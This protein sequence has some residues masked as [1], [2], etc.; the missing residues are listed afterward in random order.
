MQPG[1]CEDLCH[2]DLA[3]LRT[4]DLE[5][6]DGVADEVGKTV[7]GDGELDQ[8]VGP[9]LV[10]PI[11]PGGDR[12]R[13]EMDGLGGLGEGPSPGGAQLEDGHTLDGW[14]MGT[15]VGIDP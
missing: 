4:Q 9:S 6:L 10:D 5:P 14:V 1:P 13:R 15:L 8:G 7:D 3:K 12:R 2:H 11:H